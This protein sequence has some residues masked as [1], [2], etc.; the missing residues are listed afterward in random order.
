M[1]DMD[2]KNDALENT[3]AAAEPEVETA[4][5]PEEM[6]EVSGME[7]QEEEKFTFA[8]D[9]V[10]DL[11]YKG[12]CAYEV[13]ITVAAA[14][15]EKET[16]TQFDELKE[17]VELPGFRKGKAPMKL[18]QNKFGRNVKAEVVGKL[19]EESFKKLVEDEKLRVW[20]TPEVEGLE[21]LIE[22]LKEGDDLV[23]SLSFDVAPRCDLGNYR[24]IEVE[25]PV[26]TVTED[27]VRQA[28]D[29]ARERMLTFVSVED[30]V[31]AEDQALITFEGTID[32]A[33]FPGNAAENY[34]YMMGSGRL[35]E[36]E[37]ALLGKKAGDTAEAD[38][39]FGDDWHDKALAGKTAHFSITVNEV[40]RRQLPEMDD[41][42]AKE[43]GHESLEAWTNGTRERLQHANDD[44]SLR[45]ARQDALEKIV[46]ASTF[47]VS[48]A[49]LDEMA[50]DILNSK[51]LSRE[52]LEDDAAME[53]EREAAR[54]DAMNEIRRFAVLQEI[55]DTEGV[56]ITAEDF[57]NEAA[58]VGASLNLPTEVVLSYYQ[59]EGHMSDLYTRLMREKVLNTVL[60]HAKITETELKDEDKA[61]EKEEA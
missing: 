22:G 24:G 6:D 9:P 34:P 7:E 41:D 23:F 44:Y 29:G 1:S 8:V 30:A 25:K 31:Q 47:E 12:D 60:Q 55:A 17:L 32:G 39:T 10:F 15:L 36:F 59:R 48:P 2:S 33:A 4:A 56:E 54:A 57:E 18:L 43:L 26:V 13:K 46:A 58:T 42:L 40:K 37:Q 51:A 14:N 19:V 21:D 27:E 16:T 53:K 5:A 20:K 11:Q 49:M 61:V 52:V 28:M 45:L 35:P 3:D 50:R 38:V